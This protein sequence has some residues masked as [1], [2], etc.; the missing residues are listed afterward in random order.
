MSME[1]RVIIL[2][3][4]EL[5]PALMERFMGQG[6]L[7]GF[8]RLYSEAEVWTT[9]AEE[10]GWKLEPWIQ[11][12]TVHT[13]L[14]ADQHQV[15][16]LDDAARCKEKRL[17]DLVSQSGKGPCWICGSMNGVIQEGF[18]GYMLPDPWCSGRGPSPDGMFDTYYRFVRT[19]VQEYTNS[20]VPLNAGD[21]LRFAG[22]V[23]AN[24]LSPASAAM[25]GRQLLQERYEKVG[26]RRAAV[27]DHLQW[28]LFSHHYKR[29]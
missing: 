7:P 20:E 28:G 13:G 4:N 6:L 21:Y 24:G 27:L 26:W 25:V 14:S 17:W 8:S 18:D 3:F 22:W 15:Y 2:E 5:T 1:E 16:K 11:W 12:V 29:L 23:A 9:D 10:S 19:Q